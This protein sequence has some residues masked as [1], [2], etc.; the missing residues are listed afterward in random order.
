MRNEFAEIFQPVF[1]GARSLNWDRKQVRAKRSGGM[2]GKK[3]NRSGEMKGDQAKK[4]EKATRRSRLLRRRADTLLADEG[5]GSSQVEKGSQAIWNPEQGER[6]PL[7][8]IRSS[9]ASEPL[10]PG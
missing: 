6:D 8:C 3:R 1:K 7:C 4:T 10:M 5:S 9:I 2:K